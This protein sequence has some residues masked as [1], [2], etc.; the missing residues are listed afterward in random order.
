MNL[1]A[2]FICSKQWQRNQVLT[3]HTFV[4]PFT[5]GALW[6]SGKTKQ[7]LSSLRELHSKFHLHLLQPYPRKETHTKVGI[8][9]APF[10]FKD[11][12][13]NITRKHKNLLHFLVVFKKAR[14]KYPLC[15][16]LASKTLLLGWGKRLRVWVC[17]IWHPTAWNLT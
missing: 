5:T 11:Q 3:A 17:G 9:P 7:S 2:R 14:R 4:Q 16:L 10:F 8:F 13:W 6:V 12:N 15:G 1:S